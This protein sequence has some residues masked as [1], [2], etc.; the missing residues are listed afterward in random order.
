MNAVHF[1]LVVFDIETF[2]TA[3]TTAY[4]VHSER[5]I[6][7][8]AGIQVSLHLSCILSASTHSPCTRK[9]KVLFMFTTTRTFLS[10]A[11]SEDVQGKQ[12][13][14]ISLREGKQFTNG[15]NRAVIL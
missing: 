12:M 1:Y 11:P 8:F 10:R 14:S 5:S 15:I 7:W 2:G 6:L 9:K 4:A 3:D 13:D